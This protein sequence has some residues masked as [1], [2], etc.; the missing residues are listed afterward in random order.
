MKPGDKV[1]VV[2]D[3]TIRQVT[4]HSGI[5]FEVE[6]SKEHYAGE[7]TVWVDSEEIKGPVGQPLEGEQ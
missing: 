4:R 5:C 7:R 3:G 2:L 6:L 1:T